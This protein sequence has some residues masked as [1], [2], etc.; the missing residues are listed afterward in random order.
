MAFGTNGQRW[1]NA[2]IPFEIDAADFPVG[3]AGRAAIGQAITEWNDNT[4]IRLVPRSD[5][6]DFIVFEDTGTT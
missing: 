2:T 1:Q 5:E 4:V 3:S 6:G